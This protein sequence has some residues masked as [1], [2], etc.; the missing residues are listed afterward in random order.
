LDGGSN[1][2][3]FDE[4]FKT[5]NFIAGYGATLGYDSFIGPLE[6]TLMGSNLNSKPLIFLN[7]GFWF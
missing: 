5:D 6:V 4:V 3:D 2:E 1:E 7:L